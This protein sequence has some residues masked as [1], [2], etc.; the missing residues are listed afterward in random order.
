ML[1]KSKNKKNN[2]AILGG[3]PVRRK[4][5]FVEPLISNEEKK[6]LIKAFNK[7]NFSRYIGSN[8]EDLKE[9][10][11]SKSTKKIK[12]SNQ[13]HYLGGPNVRKFSYDVAKKFNVKYVIPTNSATSAISICV[14]AA[15]LEPGDEIIVPAISYTATAT[16]ILMF[17]CIPVFVD[18]CKDTFC[19][20]TKKIEKKITSKTKAIM[21]VHLVGNLANMKEIFKIA[22]KYGLKVIEDAAQAP[23]AKYYGKFAGTLGLA[24]ILSLQQ[25]KNIMTGEGG[26][27]LTNDKKLAKRARLLINHGEVFFDKTSS[28]NELI[29]MVGM[30]L[31]MTELSAALGIAQ[32]KKLDKVNR[33]RT[34]NAYYLSKNLKDIRGVDVQIIQNEI[35][36]NIKNIPHI[37]VMKFDEKKFGLSRDFF[38]SA[39]RSEGIPVGTGYVRPMYMNPMFLKKIAYGGKGWPWNCICKKRT[40]IS[41]IKYFEGMCP[42]S[43]NLLNKEFLW[44][45]HI[46]HSSTLK[47][48]K[49]IIYSIK[50]IIS[51]KSELFK[52]NKNIIKNLSAKGPQRDKVSR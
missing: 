27:I 29:N 30:N 2:L 13:F 10:L 5:F 51:N 3:K 43:E 25:S 18:I 35:N 21:P 38:I 24:G 37:F 4:P 39:L 23:G 22:S 19:L 50:K 31:R 46:A 47:D 41:K 14:G 7:K 32:L 33:I 20:D 1:K 36:K 15:G 6:L 34:K 9:I 26:L 17:G 16:A 42:V 44:F 45:Y 52:I 8:S 40:A 12:D 49:D 28:K 48:M 11:I